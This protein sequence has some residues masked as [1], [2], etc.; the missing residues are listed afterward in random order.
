[1]FGS[2]V[3][4]QCR[5]V[6]LTSTV[7]KAR[8]ST[9]DRAVWTDRDWNRLA[10]DYSRGEWIE[11]EDRHTYRQVHSYATSSGRHYYHIPHQGKLH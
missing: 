11:T 7:L 5:T 1:M 2:P 10:S 8:G 4:G 6:V 3:D 9:Q